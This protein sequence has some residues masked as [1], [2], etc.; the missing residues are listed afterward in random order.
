MNSHNLTTIR[1]LILDPSSNDAELTINTLRNSGIAVR[2]TQITSQSELESALENQKVWDLFLAKDDVQSISAEQCLKI[3]QHYQIDV[4]MILLT[5][6]YSVERTVEAMGLGMRDVIPNDNE[7]YFKLVVNRELAAVEDRRKRMQADNILKETEKRNELL[8]DSSRDAIAY[9]H[10]G[11][12][13]YANHAYLELFGYD[14]P[15][16]LEIMPIMNL[17]DKAN[18]EEFKKYLKAHAKG[19]TQE[20]FRF[21]GLKADGQTFDAMLSMSPSKYDGEE[22]T[23]VYLKTGGVSDEV[24]EEKL[25]EL[26]AQ[27][28]LT[29]LY[30]QH[31]LKDQIAEAIDQAKANQT[32]F[33]VYY[34]ELDKWDEIQDQYGIASTDKYL[35]SIASW[36]KSFCGD[37]DVVARTGDDTFAILSAF[38]NDEQAEAFGRKLTEDFAESLFEAGD[39]TVKNSLSTGICMINK[40]SPDADKVLS[41]AHF[42]ST[43]V[44]SQGG[45]AIRMHDSSMDSLENREDAETA[46]EISDAWDEGK[47]KVFYQPIVKIHG[48]VGQFYHARL[49]VLDE[50]GNPKSLTTEYKIGHNSPIALKLDGWLLE[51]SLAR[52][53]EYQQSNPDSMLKLRLSAATLLEENIADKLDKML[54]ALQVNQRNVLFE[55]SEVDVVAHLKKAIKVINDMANEGLKAGLCDFGASVDSESLLTEVNLEAMNMVQ[56]DEKLF[57]KFTSDGEAQEKATELFNYVHEHE[58]SSIA[59]NVS[60]AACLAMLYPLNVGYIFGDYIGVVSESMDFDFEGAGF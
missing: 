1:L 15:E 16:D 7:D 56:L 19:E 23:Q 40:D 24:I 33:A 35:A 4:P 34:S 27:D 14:D 58:L 36:L 47:I 13:I 22:C 49:M 25:K 29:G 10:D 32:T 42:A 17:M 8:L 6:R 18:H 39:H 20:E 5:D 50:Q 12:H 26:S 38:E 51:E 53:A 57:G 37:A 44:Q 48:T 30:N 21:T 55:F 45:N 9:I 59:P 31:Y 41:N 28:R 54:S 43:R 11:M 46:M 3:V 2:P 52:F 60:D